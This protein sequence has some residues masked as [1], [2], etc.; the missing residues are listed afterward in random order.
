MALLRLTFRLLSCHIEDVLSLN[1]RS[2]KSISWDRPDEFLLI[3]TP[4][5]MYS[6][7]CQ[8]LNAYRAGVHAYIV[9][10]SC[11][12]KFESK[13]SKFNNIFSIVLSGDATMRAQ[14]CHI[15]AAYFSSHLVVPSPRF[16]LL[17]DYNRFQT[18]RRAA[19]SVCVIFIQRFLKQVSS[20]TRSIFFCLF[21][22]T[23][24]SDRR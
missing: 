18:H 11:N 5:L 17:R 3:F 9:N 16:P 4:D 6:I 1:S 10:N 13:I 12:P 22:Q 2:S 23:W 24:L 15:H 7:A 21:S 8:N 20:Q 19:W 14:Y